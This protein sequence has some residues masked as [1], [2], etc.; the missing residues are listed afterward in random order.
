MVDLFDLGVGL[1]AVGAEFTSHATLFVAAPRGFGEGGVV[2]IDPSDAGAE[3]TDDALG[4][5]AIPREDA[6]C[7][8][9]GGVVCDVNGFV[10]GVE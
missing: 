4:L 5:G 6:G 2:G 1:V 10:L 9:V 3:A 7:K 8:A